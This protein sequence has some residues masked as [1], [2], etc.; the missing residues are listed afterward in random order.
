MAT[1]MLFIKERNIL[2]SILVENECIEVFKRRKQKRVIVKLDLEKAYYKINWDFL[3]YVM[4]RKGFG[5]LWRK[6][7][8]ECL[9]AI[10]YS[11]LVNSLPK[12]F[13]P[14]SQGP[15]QRDLLSHFS[16]PWSWILLAKLLLMPNLKAC[17]KVFIFETIRLMCLI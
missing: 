10:H 6:W 1:N 5:A 4:A 14:A 16:L 17:L 2:D 12:G 9:S 3:D 13:F 7:V 15:R 11:I 8:F